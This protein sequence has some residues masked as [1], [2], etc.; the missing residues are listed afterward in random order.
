MTTIALTTSIQAPIHRV[1]DQARNIDTHQLSASKTNEMAIAGITCG[2]ISKGETI[3]WKGKHFGFLLQHQSIITEMQEPNY[4]VDEQ[5]K[6]H[7]TSF[8]HEHHFE[9]K[10]GNTVMKDILQYETPYGLF[11][12]LFNKLLLKRHLTNFLTERNKVLKRVSEK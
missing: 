10:N 12:R 8:R 9:E 5:L 6:G 3:T 1:F 11:G 2:V 4:F 7:F